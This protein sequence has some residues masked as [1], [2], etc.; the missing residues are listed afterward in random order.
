[1]DHRHCFGAG[2]TNDL[3]EIL[4]QARIR[5]GARKRVDPWLGPSPTSSGEREGGGDGGVTSEGDVAIQWVSVV[6][7]ERLLYRLFGFLYV[8]LEVP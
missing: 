7:S 4:I 1:M 3:A 6:A 8:V 2:A 5:G